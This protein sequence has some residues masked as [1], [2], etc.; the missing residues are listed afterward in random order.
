MD[1]GIDR[2]TQAAQKAKSAFLK[3]Q[4]LPH[5]IRNDA[6]LRIAESLQAMEDEIIAANSIDLQHAEKSGLPKAMLKRLI[7]DSQKIKEVITSLRSLMSLEDPVGK[8][9]MKME[10]DEGLILEKVSCPIG[11]I[12][13][14]FESRPDALVQISSLCIKSANAV[15]LKGGR[16]AQHTNE[17]LARIIEESLLSIDARFDGAVQLLSTREEIAEILKMDGLIDLIV[18]RGSNELVRTIMNL[19]KIPVLGH[20]SGVCH[21]YVDEDADIG[22]ALKI[23]FDAKVQ[24]PAVC[25]AMETLIVHEKIAPIF[26]PKIARLYASAGVKLKGDAQTR[27][28]IEADEIRDNDWSTEYGDLV[29]NIKIVSSMEEA[30]DHINRYGSHHTDAIVCKSKERA[31]RFME[32][33]DSSSVMWNCSTRFADGYR[34]GFG[35]EVGISTNKIHA[36]GPVG[37]EGLTIYKYRLIGNGHV[38]SD[39]VGENARKFVHRRLV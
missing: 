2:I 5:R 33:V 32:L 37:L 3:I 24:Y 39:Y 30:I 7:F 38:V 16:E 13:V 14:I 25:N 34:Y 17:V 26:L 36:R 20:A 1:Y 11:V 29:L 28:I 27:N 8:V 6:L 15:I 19:T 4:S 23:C 9:L 21:T 31:T 22:I 10:L 35:A 12:C 18:P